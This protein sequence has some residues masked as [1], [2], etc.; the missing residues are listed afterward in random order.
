MA[1]S[2]PSDPPPSDSAPWKNSVRGCLLFLVI[3][4]VAGVFSGCRREEH[5][6]P[7]HVP[8]YGP[9]STE[10]A[11][12][13]EF[14]ENVTADPRARGRTLY[15]AHVR[16]R[17]NARLAR[18]GF[19]SVGGPKE[20]VDEAKRAALHAKISD[21]TILQAAAEVGALGDHSVFEKL[22]DV[23]RLIVGTFEQL[24]K[25]VTLILGWMHLQ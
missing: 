14:R 16:A 11:D 4:A 1:G 5:Q 24:E 7:P 12:R 8:Q 23:W 20:P 17:V 13:Q 18:E 2:L 25:L 10:R 9:R 19:A 6:S 3:F 15:L 21:E 22:G